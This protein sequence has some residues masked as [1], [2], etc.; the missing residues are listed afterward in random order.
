MEI[1]RTKNV[2]SVIVFPIQKNDGTLITGAAGLDSE[3]DHFADASNPDGFADCTNEATE[4]GTTGQ[5]YLALTQAESNYD[6]SVV[7]VKSSTTGALTQTVL[8]NRTN[9][10]S[11]VANWKG[12]AAAAM[13]GDAYARLGAPVGASISV[14]IAAVAAAS[15]TAVWAAVIENS[16]SALS[17]FR[18]IY[19]TLC[20][21]VSGGGT[22]TIAFRDDAD[23][24]ARVTMTVDTSGN[25][26]AVT[27]DAT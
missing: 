23:T 10:Q 8:I 26:S 5:Y 11:D 13:T 19:A 17:M 6:Y 21:K 27:K 22:T 18:L 2:A 3:I 14:D 9:Q 7:Q 25:R 1:R 15:A 4:I 16:K 12:D 20:N 24:K